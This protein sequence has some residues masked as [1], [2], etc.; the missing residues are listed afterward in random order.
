MVY[1]C[2]CRQDIF[3]GGSGTLSASAMT[4]TMSELIR[5]PRVMKKAQDE[6]RRAV[7]GKPNITESDIKELSYLRLVIKESMRLHP[8]APLLVPRLTTDKFEIMGYDIPLKT[9]IVFN[10]YAMARD[11]DFWD[12]AEV[13]MPERFEESSVD[14]KGTNYEFIPFGAGR[15]LCPGIMFGLVGMEIALSHLLYYFDWSLPE[16]MTE[17]DMS[18]I[19]GLGARRKY[20]LRLCANPAI[21]LPDDV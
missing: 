2:S 6:V 12:E 9:Q 16:G 17:L 13:F 1:H 11:P 4:W 5:N 3:A 10:A 21:A 15:R 8:P 7:G 20:D 19:G 18:E 14:F